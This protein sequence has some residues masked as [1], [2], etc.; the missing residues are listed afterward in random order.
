MV[1]SETLGAAGL[2]YFKRSIR[3]L[4]VYTYVV[5]VGWKEQRAE[6]AM[7]HA[8]PSMMSHA[9]DATQAKVVAMHMFA[10]MVTYA[11]L[12]L[13]QSPRFLKISKTSPKVSGGLLVFMKASLSGASR[14]FVMELEKPLYKW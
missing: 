9:R 4:H 7:G 8:R 12:C 3:L 6:V 14:I 11:P 10:R 2:C 5:V 13:Q 1:A